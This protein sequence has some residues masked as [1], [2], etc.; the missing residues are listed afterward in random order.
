MPRNDVLL[1]EI[2]ALAGLSV[3]EMAAHGVRFDHRELEIVLSLC[4]RSFDRGAA[5]PKSLAPKPDIEVS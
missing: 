1:R 2:Q 4:Q 5:S 3:T